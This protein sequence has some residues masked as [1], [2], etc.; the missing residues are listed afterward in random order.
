[1]RYRRTEAVIRAAVGGW[2]DMAAEKAT[3]DVL[4]DLQQ[5][6]R[7]TRAPAAD[8]AADIAHDERRLSLL[9]PRSQWP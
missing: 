4:R 9:K 6:T 7:V 8:T 3:G 2:V 5:L 1:M